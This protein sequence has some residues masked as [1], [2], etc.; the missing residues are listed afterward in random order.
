MMKRYIFI[1]ILFFSLVADAAEF[2]AS[3]S[4]SE[5]SYND[6]FQLLLKF[7]GEVVKTSPDVQI[8]DDSFEIVGSSNLSSTSIINGDVTTSRE[9][10]YNLKPKRKGEITIPAI[11]IETKGKKLKSA[12]IQVKV[13]SSKPLPQIDSNSGIFLESSVTKQNPYQREPIILSLKLYTLTETSDITISKI[14]VPETIVQQ[15]G[16]YN[17]YKA[18]KGNLAYDV[19]EWKFNITPTKS[20]QVK[21]PGFEVR[22][23]YSPRGNSVRTNIFDDP[24]INS[25]ARGRGLGGMKPFRLAFNEVIINVQE[26]HELPKQF[27]DNQWL[28]AKSV[29]LSEN[30][31]N[32]EFIQGQPIKRA[33]FVNAIGVLDSQIPKIDMAYSKDYKSYSDPE[34]KTVK[35]DNNIISSSR[36]EYFTI[37]PTKL[38]KIEFPEII[39]P[40][41]NVDKNKFEEA[42]L[43]AKIVIVKS[44]ESKVDAEKSID[45]QSGQ[46]DRSN[47]NEAISGNKK[48]ESINKKGDYQ[49]STEVISKSVLGDEVNKEE[50]RVEIKDNN[51]QSNIRAYLLIAFGILACGFIIRF[52]VRRGSV[53]VDPLLQK[54]DRM[55]SSD[56]ELLKKTYIPLDLSDEAALH[57]RVLGEKIADK[58]LTLLVNRKGVDRKESKQV[59][60]AQ[61]KESYLNVREINKLSNIS[62]LHKFLQEYAHANWGMRA[63]TSLEIIFTDLESRYPNLFAT[64]KELSIKCRELRNKFYGH[65][66]RKNSN[67]ISLNHE[68]SSSSGDLKALREAMKELINIF[69]KVVFTKTNRKQPVELPKL[70]PY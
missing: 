41:W 18:T 45:N 43:P 34:L 15:I 16:T 19:V 6:T 20:G 30:W 5:I 36:T 46:A 2:T 40:Y 38:G 65:L 39:V 29:S 11:S 50:H 53:V 25:V 63:N 61:E 56:Q 23:I 27:Q 51:T 57:Q 58:D 24:F 47:V 70:N 60:Q 13:G 54:P 52:F 66:Y 12:P 33:V 22:G 67:N 68:K 59:K 4:E 26:A 55:A 28:P 10:I 32:D 8:L 14:E 7:T 69:D 48:D 21:I 37:I 17:V 42:K 35:F 64:D 9:W 44:S 62:N 49:A 31:S 1:I 3:V